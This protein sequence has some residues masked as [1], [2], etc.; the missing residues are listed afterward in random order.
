MNKLSLTLVI[1]ALGSI[2][3]IA[4]AQSSNS[5]IHSAN[6]MTLEIRFD[7]LANVSESDLRNSLQDQRAIPTAESFADPQAVSKAEQ[8]VQEILAR[9]GYRHAQVS[10]RLDSRKDQ[11]PVITFLINQGPRF[12][13][14]KI[15]FEGNRIFATELLRAKM[16][17]C[18]ANYHKD[19]PERFDPDVFDYCL[20]KLASFERSEGYLQARFQEPRVEE[21]GTSLFV[22]IS[23]E[24]GSLYRLGRIEID[25]ADHISEE[26]LRGMLNINTG[27]VAYGE[28]IA[29]I[30]YEDLK[31]LYGEKGFIQYAAE[32]QPAFHPQPEA[33]EGLVDLKITVD[34]GQ[35]FKIRKIFFKGDS[36]PETNLRELLLIRE[37]SVYNQRLFEESLKKLDETGLFYTVDKDRDV[38]YRTDGEESLVDVEIKLTRRGA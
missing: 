34:E 15:E 36:I 22:K 8:A 30:F 10:S 6:Q 9:Y 12:S 38:D 31:A 24:E 11:S 20:H 13:I 19:E 37:G 25:G 14:A 26:Q 28:K 1:V 33:G 18:L 7:G 3:P 27:D 23:G 29:K 21:V 35:Q 2:A 4:V 32:I 17:G 5:S 16:R